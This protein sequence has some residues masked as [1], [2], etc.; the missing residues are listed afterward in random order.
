MFPRVWTLGCRVGV[1]EEDRGEEVGFKEFVNA[2][3][4]RHLFLQDHE[5]A[6]VVS[7]TESDMTRRSISQRSWGE[8]W[9]IQRILYATDPQTGDRKVDR[10]NGCCS[11]QPHSVLGCG[12]VMVAHFAIF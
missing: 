1:G 10:W 2:W 5:T 9:V 7:R 8:G 3:S 11:T 4:P 12:K 6:V